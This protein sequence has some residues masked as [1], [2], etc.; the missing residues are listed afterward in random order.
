VQRGIVTGLEVG[1]RNIRVV[2]SSYEKGAT[3][4]NV[5]A[6]VSYPSRGLR[7]GYITSTTEASAAIREALLLAEKRSGMRI[8]RVFLAIGGAGLGSA[9]GT[10]SVAIARGDREVTDLDVK[11]ASHAAENSLRDSDNIQI[12]HT[13]PLSS[14]LD[15]KRVLGRPHGMKGSQLE[16]KTLFITIQ[17]QHIKDMLAAVEEAGVTVLDMTAA[18]IAASFVGLTQAQKTAGCVFANIGAQTVSLAVFED[19]MPLAISVMAIGS[20]SITNDLALGLSIDPE[21]AERVKLYPEESHHPR[22]KVDE[23]VRA[24]LIDIFDSIESMLSKLGRS[25]LLPAGLILLGGG[26]AVSDAAT[27]GRSVLSLPSQ[28]LPSKVGESDRESAGRPTVRDAAWATVFGMC[29]LGHDLSSEDSIGIELT[30]AA[31]N[32]VVRWFRQFLP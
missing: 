8:K 26:A 1:T 9:V 16:V 4:P 18:P 25:G 7:H 13:V 19:G 11:R 31:G 21:E 15:G 17:D 23:I 10:G 20:D 32:K 6:A 5:V 24:R 22:K 2:V 14:K 30:R 29:I 28:A 27:I 3:N 12:L